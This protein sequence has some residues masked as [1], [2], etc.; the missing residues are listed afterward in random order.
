MVMDARE[1]EEN[2]NLT[3]CFLKAKLELTAGQSDVAGDYRWSEWIITG[4]AQHFQAVNPPTKS[5]KT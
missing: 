4:T 3:I 2:Y 1:A 5:Y